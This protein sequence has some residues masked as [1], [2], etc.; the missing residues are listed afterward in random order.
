[1]STPDP[2]LAHAFAGMDACLL[3]RV[4]PGSFVV[5]SE[6]PHW[7]RQLFTGELRTLDLVEA[8]PFLEGFLPDAELVWRGEVKE[9]ASGPWAQEL[10]LDAPGDSG[11]DLILEAFA[12]P[13]DE[14]RE[15]LLLQRSTEDFQEKRHILQRARGALLEFEALRKEVDRK[16]LL[17]HCIVHD[18]RG[19][20]SGMVGTMSLVQTQ[21]LEPE[22]TRELLEVGL[23]QAR[24]QESMIKSILEAFAAE[25]QD[26]ESFE[27]S[28]DKAPDLCAAVEAVRTRYG[29]AFRSVEVDCVVEPDAVLSTPCPVVG[30]A[31]RL[32]RVLEN[33]LE[34]ALR[35][36]PAGSCVTITLDVGDEEAL[37]SIADRGTG[38]PDEVQPHLFEKFGQGQR[39]KGV[40]GLGLYFCRSTLELWG[41]GIE[42]VDRPDGGALFRIR[43]RR[44]L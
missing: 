24:Y 25:V 21:K 23:E 20:L 8:A 12:V 2:I 30:R 13:N 27:T 33:L 3:E 14:R 26:L 10:P 29:S 15:L 1:M 11:R 44:A 31:D 19:P 42:Y 28:P 32:E 18:L 17:L 39:S 16:E 9:A 22:A 43:L 41:G 34:N 4:A 38:V 40:A 37:V 36:S 5:L 7:F 6:P 35:F